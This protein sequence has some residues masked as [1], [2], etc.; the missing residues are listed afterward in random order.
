MSAADQLQAMGERIEGLEAALTARVRV[1]DKDALERVDAEKMH[2]YLRA[3]RLKRSGGWQ[4]RSWVAA[5]CASGKSELAVLL[6][7]QG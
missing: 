5:A 7:V 6:E 2:A 3:L 4:Q 1:V